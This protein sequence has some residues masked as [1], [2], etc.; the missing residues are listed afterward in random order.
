M[1]D[2][3]EMVKNDTTWVLK[4]I[5]F[6]IT[7]CMGSMFMWSVFIPDPF[8]RIGGTLFIAI[9]VIALYETL[10]IEKMSDSEDEDA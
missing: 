7:F 3:I 6:I 4:L 10:M 9:G 5:R 2:I 1:K 8:V